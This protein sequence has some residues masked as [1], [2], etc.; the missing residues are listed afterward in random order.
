MS[1]K[2]NCVL[3]VDDDES[4]NFLHKIIL[5]ESDAVKNIE[6][7]ETA[8]DALTLLECREPS[9]C[10]HPELIFLDLNM[11]GMDGWD[12]LKRFTELDDE[13]KSSSLIYILTTSVNPDDR[14]RADSIKEVTGFQNKPLTG[15]VVREILGRHFTN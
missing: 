13:A 6:I 14:K 5:E 8:R 7:V 1:K 15:E 10:Q 11:P 9:N 4:T 2:L 12:F 3:L